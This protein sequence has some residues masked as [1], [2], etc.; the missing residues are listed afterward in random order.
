MPKPLGKDLQ[1]MV[2]KRFSVVLRH[3]KGEFQLKFN[4]RALVPL[5]D[6]LRLP[7]MY[8]KNISRSQI[9]SCITTINSATGCSKRAA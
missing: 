9:L 5:D 3:D 8:K 7:I 4:E 6:V 2:S 1:E